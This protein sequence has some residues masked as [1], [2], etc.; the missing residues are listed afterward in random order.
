MVTFLKSWSLTNIRKKFIVLYLLN[1]LDILFTLILLKTGLFSEANNLM[2]I[3][4]DNNFLCFFVK[5]VCPA[6]LLLFLYVRIEKATKKQLKISNTAINIVIIF[7][8]LI[9]LSHISWMS[10]LHFHYLH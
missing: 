1:V 7:Y 2:Y 10:I 9:V 5:I 8:S 6:L 3:I 4:I